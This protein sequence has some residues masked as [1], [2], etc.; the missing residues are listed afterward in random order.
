MYYI[1]VNLAHT[2]YSKIV[3]NI[4]HIIKMRMR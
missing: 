2:M 3:H 4:E 1:A